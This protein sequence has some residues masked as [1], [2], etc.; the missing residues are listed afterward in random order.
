[1]TGREFMSFRQLPGR[2]SPA[3][4]LVQL[5]D[6]FDPA[7]AC[8]VVAP[9]SGSRGVY[10]AVPLVAP[11]A[12]PK[13]CAVAYTDKGAGTDIHRYDDDTG[14]ALDGRRVAAEGAETGLRAPALPADAPEGTVA[15][16]HAHSGD[17]PEADW[18][19]YVLDAASFAL[20][21]LDAE[22]DVELDGDNVRVIAAGLS[23]G[24]GAV[25]RAAEQ[26]AHGL[27]D[28]VMALMP[29]ITAPDAP[30]LFEYATEAALLQPCAL[31]DLN[32]TMAM[33]LGNPLVAAAGQQRCSGLAIAGLIDAPEPALARERL[34]KMGFDDAAL[35]LGAVNVILDV[36]R[37]VAVTPCFVLPAIRAAGACRAASLASG[38][39]ATRRSRPGGAFGIP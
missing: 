9:A 7:R 21:L 27:I 23:N 20:A 22:F 26:D 35:S 8:L 25:L 37:S 39:S 31:G 2:N 29:N 12:L 24:G 32:A 28:G 15:V 19:L 10:G 11:W 18:G 3:R 13:G 33:V 16:S 36:W 14:V 38:A 17:H 6:N 30:H 34:V 1:M 4:V 5:P